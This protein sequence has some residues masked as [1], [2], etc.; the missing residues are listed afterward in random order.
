MIRVIG[1]AVKFNGIGAPMIFVLAYLCLVT[2][3][4]VCHIIV[5]IEETNLLIFTRILGSIVILGKACDLIDLHHQQKQKSSESD[6]DKTED[7]N[8]DKME[9]SNKES[10]EN[11]SD[12]DKM[13]QIV[14]NPFT[15]IETVSSMVDLT[16]QN[17]SDEDSESEQKTIQAPNKEG[18]KQLPDL[19]KAQPSPSPEKTVNDSTTFSTPIHGG[20]E[21]MS[22]CSSLA[23]T[24]GLRL[25]C[26]SSP[27]F[28]KDRSRSNS[29]DVENDW[30]KP[31]DDEEDE[32]DQEEVT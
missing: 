1:S 14:E 25:R 8:K 2:F 32:S 26:L 21:T 15:P 22:S 28:M 12:I 13:S 17:I 29:G 30:P 23:S 18:H 3:R 31:F 10:E 16:E 20:L 24:S 5:L 4:Y 6:K 19:L 11:V 7:S 27:D 9:E